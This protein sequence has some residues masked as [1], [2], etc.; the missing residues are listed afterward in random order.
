MS[1][2]LRDEVEVFHALHDVQFRSSITDSGRYNSDSIGSING[3]LDSS[4]MSYHG[5][6]TVLDPVLGLSPLDGGM[7]RPDDMWYVGVIVAIGTTLVGTL[8]KHSFRR[9]AL[10]K[11]SDR[12]CVM[13]TLGCCFL[14]LEPPGDATALSF[15]SMA[16]VTSCSGMALVWN[17]LLAPCTLGETL[18]RVRL[19]A[20]CTVLIGTIG[21]GS[22][23]PH[24]HIDRT[25]SEYLLLFSTQRA[26]IYFGCLSVW[27]VFAARLACTKCG[28]LFGAAFAGTL[29]GNNIMTKVVVSL[30]ECATQADSREGCNGENP[31][32]TWELYVF[33]GLAALISL[34]GAISLVLT[35]QSSEALDAIT[36]FQGSLITFG[37]LAS[38]CVLNEHQSLSADRASGYVFSLCVIVSGLAVL[39]LHEAGVLTLPDQT[40]ES[41]C[42]D[43]MVLRSRNSLDRCLGERNNDGSAPASAPDEATKLV[44][45]RKELA[46]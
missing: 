21:V 30:V 8:A 35:L 2:L 45:D 34:S 4:Q 24:E 29:L 22:F 32:N 40:V 13:N 39:A 18:T 31:F 14:L 19:Y 10:S 23:G 17:L 25:A 38:F 12:A 37:A 44:D 6:Q 15:A 43:Q 42:Y 1:A 5:V 9:A 11:T 27:L 46:P 33:F 3:S 20:A 16:I 41:E 28:R 26:L 7:I 36:I